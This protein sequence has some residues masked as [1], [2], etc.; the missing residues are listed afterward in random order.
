MKIAIDFD[1]VICKREGI[2]TEMNWEDIPMEGSIDTIVLLLQQGHEVW[3]FTSNPELDKVRAWLFAHDFPME[4]E[5]TNIKKPAHVYID[6]RAIRFTNWQDI[7]K[8]FV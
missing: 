6:D 3:V 5:V 8:Y 2:P 4:L 7:R 1:G